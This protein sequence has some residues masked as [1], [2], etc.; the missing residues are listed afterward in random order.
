MAALFPIKLLYMTPPKSAPP[1]FDD[2]QYM[3]KQSFP[4][5]FFSSSSSSPLLVNCF[6]ANSQMVLEEGKGEEEKTL[7]HH[8]HPRNDK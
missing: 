2:L 4:Q 8:H 6:L 5:C 3:Q 7:H 1:C